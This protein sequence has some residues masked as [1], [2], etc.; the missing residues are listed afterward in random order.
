MRIAFRLI[1]VALLVF[2]AYDYYQT[3]EA[4]LCAHDSL[5]SHVTRGE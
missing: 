1:V 3:R 5:L 4:A 2:F